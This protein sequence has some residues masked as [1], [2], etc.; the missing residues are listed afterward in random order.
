MI[1]R[2]LFLFPWVVTSGVGLWGGC[3]LIDTVADLV[4]SRRRLRRLGGG[5]TVV[6][7]RPPSPDHRGGYVPRPAAVPAHRIRR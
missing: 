1:S 2:A 3:H 4:E 6:R 7:L 5:A